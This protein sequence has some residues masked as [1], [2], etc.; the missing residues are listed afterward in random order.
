MKLFL[1]HGDGDRN[2]FHPDIAISQHE[3]CETLPAMA[4]VHQELDWV[5]FKHFPKT[6]DEAGIINV[7]LIENTSIENLCS[8]RV[9]VAV[10]HSQAWKDA[11]PQQKEVNL[12]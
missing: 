8:T 10:I 11:E 2:I 12:Q 5:N 6:G 1:T 3:S 7:L 4:T 9:S